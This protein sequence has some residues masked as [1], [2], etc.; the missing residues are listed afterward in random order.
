[1]LISSRTIGRPPLRTGILLRVHL[2]ALFI[3]S[4]I[5]LD[6]VLTEKILILIRGDAKIGEKG[7]FNNFVSS[8]GA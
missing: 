8:F 1:M 4:L 6:S 3:L 7:W 5:F 2:L